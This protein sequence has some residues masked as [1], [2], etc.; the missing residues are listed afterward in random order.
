MATQLHTASKGVMSR[1]FHPYY[2]INPNGGADY[3]ARL[4]ADEGKGLY[5]DTSIGQAIVRCRMNHV[6]GKGL[7]P[8]SAPETSILPADVTDKMRAAFAERADALWRLYAGDREMCD[9]YRKNTFAELQRIAYTNACFSDCLHYRPMRVRNGRYT[10]LNQVISGGAVSNK[11]NAVDSSTMIAGV[12]IDRNGSESGYYVQQS[13]DLLNDAQSWVRIPRYDSNGWLVADLIHLEDIDSDQ[14]R[15]RGIF[16]SAKQDILN[17]VAY[18]GNE[19]TSKAVKALFSVFIESEKSD[20]DIPSGK[21]LYENLNEIAEK[22]Q[23]SDGEVTLNA[24]SVNILNPG[25]TVKTIESMSQGTTFDTFV[26]LV[27]DI[28]GAATMVPR[29]ILLSSYDSNYSASQGT[30]Q[31]MDKNC[32]IERAFFASRFCEPV[33]E[34][35]IDQ[36]VR[37]GLLEAPHYFE[38]ELYRKA[39]CACT[40]RGPVA[41]N[42]DITKTVNALKTAVESNFMTAEDAT[43][44]IS[45]GKDFGEVA[46]HRAAEKRREQELGLGASQEPAPTPADD[47]QEDDTNNE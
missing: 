25:E 43:A 33:R 2:P 11:D 44:T 13:D 5:C 10:V 20:D 27:V 24:G 46:E 6:I 14:R 47:T 36:W 12:A 4:T 21:T 42:I 17:L 22:G 15:G 3:F 38:S 9:Y 28:I 41:T 37:Q 16:Q 32:S 39:W 1:G 40:W 19:E 26:N 31:D 34:E 29:Q 45:D 30:I 18:I 35:L 23:G 7:I 8:A